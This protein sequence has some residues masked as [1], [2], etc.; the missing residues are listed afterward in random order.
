MVKRKKIQKYRS[1]FTIFPLPKDKCEGK[2]RLWKDA[3]GFPCAQGI[4]GLFGDGCLEIA[5]CLPVVSLSDSLVRDSLQ[6]SHSVAVAWQEG[7]SPGDEACKRFC[8]PAPFQSQVVGD[9]AG[10][11]PDW[12]QQE[13]VH[14]ML[15][16]H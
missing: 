11:L 2:Q 13:K 8:C 16:F 4:P 7:G 5:C 3:C 1:N 14:R 15:F 12:S 9:I 10:L 6:L